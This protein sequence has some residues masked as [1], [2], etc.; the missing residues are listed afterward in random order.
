MLLIANPYLSLCFTILV[1]GTGYNAEAAA[2]RLK[3]YGMAALG[4]PVPEPRPARAHLQ[5]LATLPLS[6]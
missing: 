2:V 1:K 4:L 6:L 3:N 5:V